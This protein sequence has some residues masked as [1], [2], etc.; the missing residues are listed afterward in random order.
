MT[1]C[2][3]AAVPAAMRFRGQCTCEVHTKWTSSCDR[4]E[5]LLQPPEPEVASPSCQ[6]WKV[7]AHPALNDGEAFVLRTA[8]GDVV[9]NGLDDVT[10]VRDPG[11]CL[12][13]KNDPV[14]YE[15]VAVLCLSAVVDV[16]A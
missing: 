16:Y 2:T 7:K 10:V 5:A 8:K 6:R 4:H 15:S 11:C 13:H 3:W 1:A 12:C 14:Q 9:R